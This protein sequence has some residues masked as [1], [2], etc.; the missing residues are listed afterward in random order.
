MLDPGRAELAF[1]LIDEY[2]GQ[3][4]GTALISTIARGA[5]H[6]SEVA[7]LIGEHVS[8]AEALT[9]YMA[10]RRSYVTFQKRNCICASYSATCPRQLE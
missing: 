5:R 1:A 4:I 9:S 6:A 7:R 3:G 2:Q 8:K 10:R